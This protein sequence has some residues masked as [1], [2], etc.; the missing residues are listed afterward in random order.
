MK[1]CAN[2]AAH[3]ANRLGGRNRDLHWNWLPIAL[4]GG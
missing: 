2:P 3:H 4:C 1:G